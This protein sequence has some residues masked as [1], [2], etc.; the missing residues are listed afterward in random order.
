MF[1]SV[2]LLSF[3]AQH[4]YS[5]PLHGFHQQSVDFHSVV[6]ISQSLFNQ[7]LNVYIKQQWRQWA[8]LSNSS[9]QLTCIRVDGDS[10]Q[11]CLTPR[12]N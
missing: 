6:C 12:P 10:G 11:P 2:R 9:A 5:T 3:V 1:C 4:Y 8:A 7:L